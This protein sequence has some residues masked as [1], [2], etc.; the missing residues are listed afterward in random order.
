VERWR[1]QWC[2][3]IRQV[4]K[5]WEVIRWRAVGN[6]QRWCERRAR[7]GYYHVENVIDVYLIKV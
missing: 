2:A 5:D 4:G 6:R 1:R 3:V 7:R